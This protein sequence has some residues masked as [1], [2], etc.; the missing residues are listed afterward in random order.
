MPSEYESLSDQ[1]IKIL[2][3]ISDKDYNLI[4]YLKKF[5]LFFINR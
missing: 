1:D 2:D 3:N 4:S 5:I